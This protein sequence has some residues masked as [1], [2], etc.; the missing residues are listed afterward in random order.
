MWLMSIRTPSGPIV[1]RDGTP[2]SGWRY[3]AT[4]LALL[5]TVTT[6]AACGTGDAEE[7]RFY[8]E[9]EATQQAQVPEVQATTTARFFSG[10]P[11]AEPTSTPWPVLSELTLATSVAGDGSPQNRVK[12]ASA[13][14]TVYI[15][16]R[17]HDLTA[18]TPFVAVLGRTDNSEIARSEQSP[19]RSVQNGWIAFPFAINGTLP[20][21]EY[22]VFIYADG[23][24]LGSIVFSLY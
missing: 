7:S 22:A 11:S 10:T 23:T 13:Q 8:Q 15:A 3:V 6:L 2:R 16:A 19:E 4:L 24:L 20:G 9:Q 17:I 5:L 12:S 1:H 14:G 21:G 18:G